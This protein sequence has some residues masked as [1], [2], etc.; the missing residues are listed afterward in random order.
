MT[1]T[2]GR[3]ITI[4]RAGTGLRLSIISKRQRVSRQQTR[5]VSS[6]GER[7]IGTLTMCIDT[8]SQKGWWK[9]STRYWGWTRWM[10]SMATTTL[11]WALASTRSTSIKAKDTVSVMPC[12]TTLCSRE[13]TSTFGYRLMSSGCCSQPQN[14]CKPEG[15]KCSCLQGKW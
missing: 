2:S 14:H 9:G 12:S 5:T 11:L 1:T 6:T 8:G 7:A 15:W 3:T 4:C 10:T 13:T